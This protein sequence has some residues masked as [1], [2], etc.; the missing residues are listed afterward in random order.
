LH[1]A[2][3]AAA[4]IRLLLRCSPQAQQP[5]TGIP[6]ADVDTVIEEK[7]SRELIPRLKRAGAQG[8]VEYG[9]II[10]LV[11]VLAIAGLII[12]GPA[13]RRDEGARPASLQSSW[14]KV[15]KGQAASFNRRIRNIVRP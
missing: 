12:F 8:L 2:Q 4:L 9:L 14:A 1:Y 13:A 11:A 7:Q 15:H 5:P 10:A 6:P 3:T